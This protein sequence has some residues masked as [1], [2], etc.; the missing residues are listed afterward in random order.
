M[1]KKILT[2]ALCLV[3]LSCIMIPVFADGNTG[4]EPA[5]QTTGTETEYGTIPEQY[6]AATYPWAIF[7]E[8][9]F[10][11]AFKYYTDYNSSDSIEYAILWLYRNKDA[12]AG[13][14]I[15][16]LLRRD[17]TVSTSTDFVYN[18]P[19]MSMWEEFAFGKLT[20]DLG[21]YTLTESNDAPLV[22]IFLNS[23]GTN[24]SALNIDVKNGTIKN[25]HKYG[26]LL[27][28]G[29][30]GND[31]GAHL[32]INI[33][34]ENVSLVS[35]SNDTSANGATVC[36]F[37]S[38]LNNEGFDDYR[39]NVIL[40]RCTINTSLNRDYTDVNLT[41]ANFF[42]ADVNY[43]SA[44][45]EKY[46]VYTTGEFTADVNV[47]AVHNISE[48]LTLEIA[49]DSTVLASET[50]AVTS[51]DKNETLSASADI[52][53][54]EGILAVT[55]KSGET[56]LKEIILNPLA[57]DGTNHIYDQETVSDEYLKSEANCTAAAVYYKSCACGAHDTETSP[58]FTH[59]EKDSSNHTG[60]LV[61]NV[62]EC[63]GKDMSGIVTEYGTIPQTANNYPWAVFSEGIF[64][65]EFQYWSGFD[66]NKHLLCWLTENADKYEGKAVQILLRENYTA[67]YN[68]DE[69]NSNDWLTYKYSELTIDLGG[70]T[71]YNG[72][73]FDGGTGMGS[74][75]RLFFDSN[76]VSSIEASEL[77]INIINGTLKQTANNYGVL[78]YLGGTA[79]TDGG[80]KGV[81]IYVSNITFDT[82]AGSGSYSDINMGFFGSCVKN[83]EKT[84][85]VNIVFENCNMDTSNGGGATPAWRTTNCTSG[86]TV[87]VDFKTTCLHGVHGGD[88]I[89]DLCG[90]SFVNLTGHST[91]LGENLG[92]N[93]YA[94]IPQ[95]VISIKITVA[96]VEQTFLTG[97]LT[98]N[99]GVYKISS[100]VSSVNLRENITIEFFDNEGKSVDITSSKGISRSYTTSVFTY[101][102]LLIADDTQSDEVKAVAKALL[103]Y[104]A[105]AEEY[106][107]K[108]YNG[109]NVYDKS[110]KALVT[111]DGVT[112]SGTVSATGNTSILGNVQLVLDNA[113]KIRIFINAEEIDISGTDAAKVSKCDGFIEIENIDAANL[114]TPY[115]FTVNES[116]TVT[117]SATGAAAYVVNSGAFGESAV[118]LMKALYLYAVSVNALPE[119]V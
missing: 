119:S 77:N 80:H 67:S 19:G 27:Y 1:I 37:G 10:L 66:S 73:T 15:Q 42:Y 47:N 54:T 48:T 70:N 13:K 65:A 98:S 76:N 58:T 20:F 32:G 86:D 118:N 99:E 50:L 51:G 8:G 114:D 21:G 103:N 40:N 35:T 100:K 106:F 26:T 24:A 12:Y 6:D 104:G 102:N 115:T 71:F 83:F 36:F 17:Y 22:R 56:V 91:T 7:S 72:D 96:G 2:L 3:M 107:G 68:T 52:A 59:G 41:K 16:I 30:N 34:A 61:N 74:F 78:F 18:D 117:I 60:A 84:Y 109:E 89:C 33:T 31:H 49:K 53:S 82:K 23:N 29:V 38:A 5:A 45:L 43:K 95:N 105:Y 108:E 63:C 28:I 39:I 111:V 75:V 46:G 55:L 87:Y 116:V 4:T 44:D 11:G 94:T 101:A 69:V 14:D 81:N 79:T 97:D 64:V 92:I 88:F 90:K 25:S 113:T 9:Q 57:C 110:I 62:Y 112:V 85:P 93:F